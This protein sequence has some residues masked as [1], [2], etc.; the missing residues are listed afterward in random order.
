MWIRK[1]Q[2]QD[3]RFRWSIYI[4]LFAVLMFT[5]A[6][7]AL[8]EWYRPLFEGLSSPEIRSAFFNGLRFDFSCIALFLGPLIFLLNLPVNSRRWAKWLLYII[9]LVL[10]IMAGVL[11]ADLIYFPK[12]NRH[13]AEEIVQ[14]SHDWD[15]VISY[16]FGP[17][18]WPLLG[19]LAAFAAAV[20]FIRYK[21]KTRFAPD[22]GSPLAEGG[23]LLLI[24]ALI[25]LGIR[26][27]LGAGKALG[28]AD[29][30]NYARTP[31]AAALTTNGVFTAYQV[32]RKGRVDTE[33]PF[34]A[35]KAILVA[36]EQLFSPDETAMDARYPLMR[37]KEGATDLKNIN[38]VIVLLEGWHPRFIDS[39]SGGSYG[40][41]PVFDKIVA[42][43]VTFNNAY[44]AGLRS[45]FGFAAVLAGVPLV[46]GLPMF[47]YG[48]EMSSLSPMP[49]NFADAGYYTLFAQP[50]SGIPTACA[51]WLPS[52][53][54]KIP[55][56]GKTYRSYC[57]IRTKPPSAMIMTP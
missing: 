34:P 53:G 39:L 21:I 20:L 19:L 37:S 40:V 18:L 16:M 27:H 41:T 46:P 2:K 26:G 24:I 29:V 11:A 8:F 52:W 23:K 22:F 54:C 28:V 6:R 31:A 45:I 25:V 56:A 42:E 7:F 36:R 5:A 13:I 57:P 3:F 43:G 35:D 14:I 55:L 30:Y 47:G 1:P 33:N 38:I 4:V 9:S 44:A 10:L 49:K 12:V 15:F 32:G 51:R 48:L 50:L 17:A